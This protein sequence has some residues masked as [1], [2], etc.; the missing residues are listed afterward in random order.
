MSVRRTGPAARNALALALGVAALAAWW[1]L[2]G[3]PEVVRALAATDAVLALLGFLLLVS[4]QLLRCFRWHVL[5]GAIGPVPFSLTFRSLYA[6]ELLNTILPVKLGD[7]GRAVAISRVPR[8]TLGSAVATIVLDRLS[9]LLVRVAVAPLVVL[10]PLA[11]SRSLV[12]SASLYASVLSAA[13]GAGLLFR[14]RPGLFPA[15]ARRGLGFLPERWRASIEATFSSF[16]TSVVSLGLNR[17]MAAR[18]LLLSLLALG[19][20]ASAF[21]LWFRAA[22]ATLGVLT[23][24]VGTAF[25]DLL[26]LLP[27]PPAGLGVA[28]WSMTFVFSWTLGAPSLSTSVTA[29][30]A[31]GLWLLLVTSFGGVSLSALS[32]MWPGRRGPNGR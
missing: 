28:E 18:V 11:A 14:H 17:T 24:L 2:F 13:A 22:G 8:F 27:A 21:W 26:A 31:H 3:G 12:L 6:A 5:L 32:E 20:Q 19:L 9:G 1:R 7:A 25:L 23:V 30:V 16:A 4:S 15:L 29:L 10:L